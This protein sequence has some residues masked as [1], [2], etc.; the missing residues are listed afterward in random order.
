V[1]RN[2]WRPWVSGVYCLVEVQ[3]RQALESSP[4]R[5][6]DP[7]SV[8]LNLEVT[9]RCVMAGAGGPAAIMVSG[10][11]TSGEVTHAAARRSSAHSL[12]VPLV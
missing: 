11:A 5:N 2:V 4:H 6:T 1:T 7:V 9:F 3:T 8:D 12:P 10:G